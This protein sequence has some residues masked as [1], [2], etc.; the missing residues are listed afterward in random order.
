MKKTIL[1]SLASLLC[2]SY[3]ISWAQDDITNAFD[4]LKRTGTVNENDSEMRKAASDSALRQL[5][6]HKPE[7]GFYCFT[8]DRMHDIRLTN[9]IPAR[10]AERPAETWQQFKGTCQPGEFYTWQIGLFSPFKTLDNVT[11]S[12]SDLKSE[13]GKRIP[14]SAFQCFNQGGTDTNGLPFQKE[15][16]V[17]QG[18]VQALWLGMNIPTAAEGIYK[19]KV[20]VRENQSKPVEIDIEL[21]VSGT[22]IAHHGDDADQ[23]LANKPICIAEVSNMGCTAEAA[24]KFVA[25]RQLFAPGKAVNAGGVATSGLEMTQN[26]MRLSWSEA[27]VDDKLHYI[28]HNI[29]DQCVKYGRE[30]D[31]YVDYVKGANIAGFM[32]VA[33][34]MMAQGIV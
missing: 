4:D 20:F 27:E 6:S 23:L 22:P 3:T 11:V 8:E 5:L 26:A 28:M 14:A 12:F 17:P 33:N 13:Q 1:I 2:L 7:A 21:T 18:N 10:W 34:A 32:K 9:A 19:G 15:I 25:A 29:H 24:E 30:A 16:D 31:G